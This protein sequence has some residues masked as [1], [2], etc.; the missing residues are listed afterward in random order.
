MLRIV[1]VMAT[2]TQINKTVRT[3]SA[4]LGDELGKVK[5]DFPLRGM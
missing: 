1:R 4:R 2:G 3:T 5:F